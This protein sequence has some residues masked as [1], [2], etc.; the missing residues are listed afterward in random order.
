MVTDFFYLSL[1]ILAEYYWSVFKSILTSDYVVQ[2]EIKKE[3]IALAEA[4]VRVK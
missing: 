4:I 3:K 1:F 2:E